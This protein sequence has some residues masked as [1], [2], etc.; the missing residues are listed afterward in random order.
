MIELQVGDLYLH[1]RPDSVTI[2]LDG[3]LIHMGYRELSPDRVVAVYGKWTLEV[4]KSGE[5]MVISISVDQHVHDGQLAKGER[6][7]KK[8]TC[9]TPFDF[10]ELLE[11]LWEDRRAVLAVRPDGQ[12]LILS[13]GDDHRILK[14]RHW[15]VGPT[16]LSASFEDDRQNIVEVS[17]AGKE[18]TVTIYTRK[19]SDPYAVYMTLP[20]DLQD[21]QDLRQF[22][23]QMRRKK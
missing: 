6:W 4:E 19:G 11:S 13:I 20:V 10:S 18:Q 17:A 22:F 8:V 21:G 23:Y 15:M 3:Q 1:F 5:K 9:R 7:A 16:I 2:S 14:V 12:G